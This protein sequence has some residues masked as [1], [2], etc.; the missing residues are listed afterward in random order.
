MKEDRLLTVSEAARR[1]KVGEN[2]I[3]RWADSG[4]LPCV[5]TPYGRAFRLSDVERVKRSGKP[6]ADAKAD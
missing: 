5:P 6:L 3:R 4:Q 1:L 2:T